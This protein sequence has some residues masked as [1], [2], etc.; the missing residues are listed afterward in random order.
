MPFDPT[1]ELSDNVRNR[2][3][4]GGNWIESRSSMRHLIVSPATEEA[5]VEIRLADKTD[6][7]NAVM[8]ARFA[9]DSGPWPKMSGVERSVYLRR[10]SEEIKQRMP[11]F[12]RLMTAQ[13][14]APVSFVKRLIQESPRRFEYFA[15]LAGTYAFEERRPTP[16]GHAR[17]RR[18]PIG[19]AALIAPWNV[20]LN[21]LALKIPAALAAG[22]TVVV[23]SPPDC[24]FDALLVAECAEAAGIPT[25]VLNV[26]TA[27]RE[28]NAFL[29][30]S[31][32]VDKISFT[33]GVQA[34]LQV[35]AAA[36][37]RFARVTL[38]LGGK[39][40]AIL[41]DD[42]ELSVT[43]PTLAAFSM[44]FS[45]QMCVAQSRILVPKTRLDEVVDALL[46][47]ITKLKI[48]D[49]WETD[50][51]VGPVRNERQRDRVLDYIQKGIEQG[52]RVITGGG[53][54]T[55]FDKG[56]Y[57]DPTVFTEV[58]PTMTIAQEEIFGPVVAIMVYDSVHDAVRIANDSRFGL[59][60][61]VFSRDQE[62][63]YDVACQ[64]K[65]GQVSVNG[66]EMPASVPFGGYKFS[67]I[68]REG[69]TEGLET[70][71]E[72]KAIFMPGEL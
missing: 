2:F 67:G 54:S 14:G 58:T 44:S 1:T 32:H 40:A 5:I 55:G 21:V 61:T 49:P 17:V 22:C 9:F 63:A 4:I 57:L 56:Y 33:G 60:G 42:A 59:S 23:K 69:G 47:M 43:L 29:V 71:L 46:S 25:G 52:G 7:E 12:A 8:A 53:R 6:V 36:S 64:I 35:A 62:R 18:E 45:G 20:T 70:Y 51:H 27:D 50:T 3:Y 24:P 39:S 65:T 19:V 72:T 41:L 66:L 31:P 38:E 34:G 28:E 15:E 30:A 11:L 16:R 68:G 37:E 48:G 26:I 13:A 10:L